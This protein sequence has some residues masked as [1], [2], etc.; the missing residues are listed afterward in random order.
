M[1]DKTR[2][3]ELKLTRE[4]K[5]ANPVLA[6]A[7]STDDAI[8]YAACM[9]GGIY[10]VESGKSEPVRIGK[11]DSYA[12]SVHLLPD[13]RTVVSGGYDGTLQWHDAVKIQTVRQVKAHRFWS[14]Q[15]DL[16]PNGT[17]VASVT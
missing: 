12:S 7:V 6:L 11:H 14:W 5:L 17:L 15:T 16:S 9:D 4:I 1:A 13:Q 2:Q 10:K 3:I 8:F